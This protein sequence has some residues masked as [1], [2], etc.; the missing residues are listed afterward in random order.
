MSSV[1][2]LMEAW[3]AKSCFLPSSSLL[4]PASTAAV[5]FN[6][7][8][9]EDEEEGEE[10]GEEGGEEEEEIEKKFDFRAKR[11]RRKSGRISCACVSFIVCRNTCWPH[12]DFEH[13]AK[14]P[15]CHFS[16]FLP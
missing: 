2:S 11:G 14:T 15:R 1:T 3:S 7:S 12:G 8:E 4:C 13:A 16:L 5:A 6:S 9:E 10:G